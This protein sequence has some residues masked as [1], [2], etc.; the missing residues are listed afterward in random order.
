MGFSFFL[1]GEVGWDDV[2]KE[3]KY[4]ARGIKEILHYILGIYQLI[5]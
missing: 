4:I 3:K 5:V 2:Y 1:F